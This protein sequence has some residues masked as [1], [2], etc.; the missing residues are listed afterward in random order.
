MQFVFSCNCHPL[1]WDYSQKVQSAFS[2]NCYQLLWGSSCQKH[3][4]TRSKHMI[5][6]STNWMM[7]ATRH[8]RYA[9][10]IGLWAISM[11]LSQ[12]WVLGLGFGEDKVKIEFENLLWNIDNDINF[13]STKA[14]WK[15][16]SKSIIF[17]LNFHLP[18]NLH[19]DSWYFPM[20]IIFNFNS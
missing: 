11:N 8:W 13:L 16:S 17:T 4:C 15:H 10:Q 7:N 18:S 6:F 14:C 12:N 20:Q 9:L 19:H 1:L 3:L 5:L 2:C